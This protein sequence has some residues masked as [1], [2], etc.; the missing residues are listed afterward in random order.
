[1]EASEKG[2]LLKLLH[3]PVSLTLKPRAGDVNNSDPIKTKCSAGKAH[4]EISLE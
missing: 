4:L 1:M 2:K 3:K